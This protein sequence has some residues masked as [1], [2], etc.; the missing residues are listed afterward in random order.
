MAFW[1]AK[2]R[3]LRE[4]E[5]RAFADAFELEPAPALAEPLRED[6]DL[7]PGAFASVYELVRPGQPDVVVF[8]QA[9]DREGPAGTAT[10]LRIGVVVRS[11]VEHSAV[12]LRASAKRHKVLEGLVAGRSGAQRL[13][14][15]SDPEF[16]AAVS[17]YAREVNEAAALL[18]RAVRTVLA[19]LLRE[20]DEVVASAT[21]SRAEGSVPRHA[22]GAAPS[23]AIGPRNLYLALEVGVP[24]ELDA[25]GV[26]MA[27]LLS[28]HVALLSASNRE[29]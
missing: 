21:A 1:R 22:N 29:R 12:S 25:L 11:S 19:R 28:L 4:R 17:V 2:D 8:E 6:L 26:L 13:D 10:G 24:F 14:G 15:A 16:D 20:A 27:D 5:W 18:T 3:D 7:G 23:V 9:N